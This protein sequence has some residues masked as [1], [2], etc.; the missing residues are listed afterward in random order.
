MHGLAPYF[1]GGLT[2]VALTNLFATIP[3]SDPA[4][5]V[6]PARAEPASLIIPDRSHKGDRLVSRAG[7]GRKVVVTLIEVVGGRHKV[8]VYRD[9][10]GHA[11][12]T[13]DPRRGLSL[14]V[15]NAV[16]PQVTI[17]DD[18]NSNVVPRN[19]E[20]APVSDPD[21]A[22]KPPPLAPGCEPAV[23]P[24]AGPV[25]ARQASRCVA[26]LEGLPKW[27]ALSVGP[28]D[29]RARIWRR[30]VPTGGPPAGTA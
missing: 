29:V 25:L 20:L 17:G 22:S 3:V 13:S 21:A 11:V 23:S 7:G 30:P 14:A 6:T 8:T 16:L 2:A 19:T 18:Q 28:V 24:L 27:D 15:K 26:V 12:F 9:R 1:L 10:D 4:T 5:G